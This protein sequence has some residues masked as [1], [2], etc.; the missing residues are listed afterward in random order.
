MGTLHS[1]SEVFTKL[2]GADPGAVAAGCAGFCRPNVPVTVSPGR[3]VPVKP[4]AV[5]PGTHDDGDTAMPP[6]PRGQ[7][8]RPAP[9]R[10]SRALDERAIV[11]VG[12]RRLQQA[13]HGLGRGPTARARLVRLVDQRDDARRDGVAML[14]PPHT[15]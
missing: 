8:A 12:G 7:S 9:R 6:L 1:Y 5:V 4:G 2:L 3:T 11:Q 15:S 13:A 14:V 10:A